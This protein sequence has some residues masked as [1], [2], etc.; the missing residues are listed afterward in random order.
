M[1]SAGGLAIGLVV[2]LLVFA[3]VAELSYLLWRKKKR[4]SSIRRRHAEE[5]DLENGGQD[6]YAAAT[7]VTGKYN[8]KELFHLICWKNPST[9]IAKPDSEHGGGGGG[10]EEESVEL[11][12]MRLH[13]LAG[14]PRFLFTTKEETKEDLVDSEDGRSRVGEFSS[15]RLSLSRSKS[16]SEIEGEDLAHELSRF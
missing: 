4:I 6:D 7:A 11:E 14:P 9:V 12:L 13:N 10:A 1:K 5:E 8:A 2:S 15:R 3:F 16:L